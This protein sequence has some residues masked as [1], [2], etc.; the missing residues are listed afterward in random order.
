[1]VARVD[2]I[3]G[4]GAVDAAQHMQKHQAMRLEGAGSKKFLAF[5]TVG[6]N[7]DFYFIESHEQKS[8]VNHS[9]KMAEKAETAKGKIGKEPFQVEMKFNT[10]L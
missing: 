9:T 8:L 10:I 4:D 7:A 3:D 1:M 2:E 6:L 5:G